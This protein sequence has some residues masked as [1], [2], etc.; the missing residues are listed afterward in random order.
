MKI[1]RAQ[2]IILSITSISHNSSLII[3]SHSII[4]HLSPCTTCV[5]ATCLPHSASRAR[6][7]S[8]SVAR[9]LAAMTARARRLSGSAPLPPVKRWVVKRREEWW[10]EVMSGE[11]RRWVVK[12]RE[13]WWRRQKRKERG[14]ECLE[15]E[16]RGVVKWRN[17]G[18]KRRGMVRWGQAKGGWGEKSKVRRGSVKE[19]RTQENEDERI[20]W[21]RGRLMSKIITD[22]EYISYCHVK[23]ITFMCVCADVCV[24]GNTNCKTSFYAARTGCCALSVRWAPFIGSNVGF[25]HFACRS[26]DVC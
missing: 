23:E 13:E 14:E 3:P 19:E 2:T 12:R 6:E 25:L 26:S 7:I 1:Y 16:W 21:Q 22:D 9:S 11:E 20:W 4:Y 24:S 10:R 8:P 18:T 5:V 17:E 15:T